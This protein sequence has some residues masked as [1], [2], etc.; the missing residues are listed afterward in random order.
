V[1]NRQEDYGAIVLINHG[2][3][4]DDLNSNQCSG[5]GWA[6]MAADARRAA[7]VAL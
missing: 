4:D 5:V 2:M 6:I 7:E 1:Y 3:H